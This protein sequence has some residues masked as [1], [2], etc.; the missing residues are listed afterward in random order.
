MSK[1]HE[2]EQTKRE[3]ELDGVFPANNGRKEWWTGK[4]EPMGKNYEAER[5]MGCWV[6]LWWRGRSEGDGEQVQHRRCGCWW[7]SVEGRRGKGATP[8]EE[9][10]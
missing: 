3:I 7:W 9:G 2:L 6:V 8:R 1:N 10:K 4:P 5:G